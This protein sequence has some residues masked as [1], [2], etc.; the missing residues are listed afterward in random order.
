MKTSLL[1][2]PNKNTSDWQYHPCLALHPHEENSSHIKDQEKEVDS[3][4]VRE[5]NRAV[6]EAEI[7]DERRMKNFPTFHGFAY[8]GESSDND[9]PNEAYYYADSDREP[10]NWLAASHKTT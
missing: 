8:S 4:M 1:S 7:E 3:D 6:F 9:D 5:Y 10:K 2:M